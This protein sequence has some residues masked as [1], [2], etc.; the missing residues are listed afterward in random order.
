[1]RTAAAPLGGCLLALIGL[2]VYASTGAAGAPPAR[3]AI[4][5][6]EILVPTNTEMTAAFFTIRNAGDSPDTLLSVRS[7]QLGAG[8]LTTTAVAHGAGRM[9][10]VSGFPVPP[11]RTV[12]MVPGGL[13]VMIAHPPALCPGQKVTFDLLFASGGAL[14]VQAVAVRPGF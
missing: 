14:R 10:P 4:T 6:A 5:R 8:A 9:E 2:T 12:H 11:H 13:D 1:V 3:I 7:P